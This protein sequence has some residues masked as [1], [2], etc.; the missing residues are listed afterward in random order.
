ML[1]TENKPPDSGQIQAKYGFAQASQKME[2]RQPTHRAMDMDRFVAI[3]PTSNSENASGTGTGGTGRSAPEAP[4]AH[5]SNEWLNLPRPWFRIFA[6]L[7][8][9][10]GRCYITRYC[11]YYA[12]TL[13]L[14]YTS[15]L[16]TC[17]RVTL[18]SW[19][20]RVHAPP[21]ESDLARYQHSSQTLLR[22]CNQLCITNANSANSA[23][24]LMSWHYHELLF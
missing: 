21:A 6:T 9:F 17:F 2:P 19:Y 8:I 1:G 24:S 13:K 20:A 3:P 5:D 7:Q 14:Q 18:T 11:D 15:Q 22:H 16:R 23:L 12:C 4:P 10:S